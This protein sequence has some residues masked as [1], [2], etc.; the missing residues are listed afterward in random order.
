MR[1]GQR[2]WC[3]LPPAGG[4]AC[5]SPRPGFLARTIIINHWIYNSSI[6]ARQKGARRRGKASRT[7]R[8][9]AHAPKVL[10]SGRHLHSSIRNWE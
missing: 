5:T 2:S 8:G 1:Q 6:A 3:L 9:P 10:V 7:D 4:A